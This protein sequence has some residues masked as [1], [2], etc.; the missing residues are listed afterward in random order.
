MDVSNVLLGCGVVLLVIG[1]IFR[2]WWT[3]PRREEDRWDE[4]SSGWRA[5]RDFFNSLP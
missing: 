5:F 1:V 4:P 2:A 3:W